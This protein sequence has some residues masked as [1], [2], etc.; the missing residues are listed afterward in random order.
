MSNTYIGVFVCTPMFRWRGANDFHPHQVKFL[1]DLAALTNDPECPYEFTW[2][3]INA[4][5]ARARNKLVENFLAS[6]AKW[7]LFVDDDIEGTAA[8]VVRLIE[9]KRPIVSAL[10]TTR[11][12]HPHWVANFMHEVE[13]QP[14]GLLQVIEAGTGF[15]LYHRQV[16]ENL[17]NLFPTIAYTDRDTGQREHGFF[18]QVVM[19]TDLKPDG[20]FL[21][22]DFFCDHLCRHANMGIFVDTQMKLRH[23]GPDNTLYPTGDW[24]PIPID[25]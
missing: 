22:E 4:G 6:E 24:P 7:L 16:F 11:E 20:D 1:N 19:S 13:L 5:I 8:D 18:Q 12:A 23:R 3:T 10:Y 14:N 21:P 2:S 17:I 25:A 15:K 9:H